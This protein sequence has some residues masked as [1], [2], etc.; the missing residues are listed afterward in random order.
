MMNV[1]QNVGEQE[2]FAYLQNHND[3]KSSTGLVTPSNFIKD[4]EFLFN[5]KDLHGY[6]MP[7]MCLQEIKLKDKNFHN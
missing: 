1:D 7:L 6:L 4:E 5:D 3:N 2:Y